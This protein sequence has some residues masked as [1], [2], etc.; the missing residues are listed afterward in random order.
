MRKCITGPF[1]ALFALCILAAF[2]YNLPPINQRL[3][4]KVS[5]IR[6]RLQYALAPPDEAVFVPQSETSLPPPAFTRIAPTL[7]ATGAANSTPAESQA[8]TPTAE[9]TPTPAPSP[10]PRPETVI[11]DGVVYVDQ[12]NR[13][14]YCGP[15]NLAMALNFW[16]WEGTRDDIARVVKPGVQDPSLDFIQQGRLDKNVMPYELVDFANNQTGLRAL[17][18]HGGDEEMLK[19]LIAGGFPVLVEKG[20]YE[21][22]YTGKVAWLGHYLFTTGYDET[23]G[24]FIVQD[25]YLPQGKDMRVDFQ[26]YMDGWRSFNYQFMVFYPPEREGE[27]LDL[28]GPYAD[29]TEASQRAVEIAT[30]E[31]QSFSGID[32]FFAWF[33]LGTSHVQLLQY[34]E[35]AQAYDQAFARYASLENDDAQR[36]YRIMWYQTGPYWAYYYTGRYQDVINLAN[37]TLNETTSEPTLEESLYWRGLAYEAL[38][39]PASAIADLQESVRLNPNFAPGL[40]QLN[41]ILSGG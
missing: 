4:I 41:R 2:A 15:A 21:A 13:W 40:S 37:T 7:P 1:L 23:S 14:N 38:G 30:E 24:E 34:N 10:T 22:D 31:T 6:S 26:T 36:P 27:V 8:G 20:Y 5:E 16:G 18:R 39:D 17:S 25:A 3:A 32:E 33:N 12:H 35:A 19:R 11:L 28:L 9:A 29:P